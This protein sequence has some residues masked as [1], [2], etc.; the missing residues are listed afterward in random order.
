MCCIQELVVSSCV[1]YSSPT[2]DPC[3][4]RAFFRLHFVVPLH[5]PS[6]FHLPSI[7]AEDLA[8]GLFAIEVDAD[9]YAET[10]AG[11]TPSVPRT[12][13]SEADFQAQKASYT[14]KVDTGNNYA[15]FLKA[16]PALSRATNGFVSTGNGDDAKIK[17]G[18]KDVQLL[19]YAVGEMY[20]DRRYGE[21]V[22]L[23]EKVQ[24]RCEVDGKLKS[25]LK[26]WI[27]RCRGKMEESGVG[28]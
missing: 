25:T 20:Y 3:A 17:L 12:F 21:V 13:Q 6:T 1:R 23:C 2:R 22:E 15:E 14:A 24:G 7:M 10:A 4:A 5:P 19:G 9:D 27:V 28:S 16:V 18:K 26:R 11:D 8:N